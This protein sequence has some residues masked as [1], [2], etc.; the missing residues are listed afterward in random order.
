MVDNRTAITSTNYSY[1]DFTEKFSADELTRFGIQPS[2]RFNDKTSITL[3][4]V[5]R[6]VEDYEPEIEWGYLN[7]Q[8]SDN[9]SVRLGL[10]RRPL[11]QYTDTL[12]V[13]Y[14]VRWV[15]P[16]STAY[17][18]IDEFY[19]SIRAVNLHYDGLFREWL[20]STELY[21]G[22][23]SGEGQYGD[24][25]TT[26][27]S[28]RN[29]GLVF[30]LERNNYTFRFGLH[31]SVFSMSVNEINQ[32]G[33][34][35]RQFGFN[36]LASE[37]LLD[38]ETARFYSIAGSYLGGNWEVFGEKVMVDIEDAFVPEINA[39]YAGFQRTFDNV[40]LH[41]TTGEQRTTALL[42][43]SAS[44]L[45]IAEQTPDTVAAAVLNQAGQQ[46]EMLVSGNRS[47]RFS[48]ATGVR[49][50]VSPSLALNAELERVTDKLADASATM[51][52]VSM[53]FV[54]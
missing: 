24:E 16:P 12:Y 6:H 52:S 35:L 25:K 44:L 48:M 33:Q 22:Q 29:A 46:L 30:D 41:F 5:A 14:G 54:F 38:D 11:F 1:S 20:Y 3:Q 4:A 8:L 13:G 26:N 18:D 40:S 51:L 9:A 49:V 43:P 10:M 50:D 42:D 36:D 23:G 7:Y 15:Q 21:F 53:D 32:L 2:Y 39:W 17:L 27:E 19:G 37:I 31:E 45:A 28:H 34:A 47:R